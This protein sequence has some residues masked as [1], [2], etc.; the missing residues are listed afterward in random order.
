M[1]SS[2]SVLAFC[3]YPCHTTTLEQCH[4]ICATMLIPLPLPVNCVWEIYIVTYV[5][6]II[7]HLEKALFQIV[8]RKFC[9]IS[10]Y[11]FKTLNSGE[12]TIFSI[13]VVKLHSKPKKHCTVTVHDNAH[14]YVKRLVFVNIKTVFKSFLGEL[15]AIKV[16]N[17]TDS[18]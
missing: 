17:D 18:I 4:I 7:K 6:S 8:S 13:F 5:L 12:W 15:D 2:V 1:A 16:K 10:C 3:M 9:Q 14:K 11:F